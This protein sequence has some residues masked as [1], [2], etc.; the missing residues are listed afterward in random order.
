MVLKKQNKQTQN[1]TFTPLSSVLDR[2]EGTRLG[3]LIKLYSLPES[4]QGFNFSLQRQKIHNLLRFSYI[5]SMAR[6]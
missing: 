4:L 5:Q 1:K 6:L 3:R 2:S